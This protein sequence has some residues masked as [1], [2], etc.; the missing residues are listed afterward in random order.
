M[1]PP[2]ILFV[3]GFWEGPAPFALVTA[4]LQSAG[5]ATQ[6]ATLPSTGTS[7]PGNPSMKD[8]IAAV[9]SAIAGLVDTEG[10]TV[11]LVLHSAGGFVGSNA[12][13][14]LDVKARQ[15][16]GLKGGVCR[17]VFLTG[18]VFPE[19]YKHAS[20]PFFT[21]DVSPPPFQTFSSPASPLPPPPIYTS[22]PLHPL[23]NSPP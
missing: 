2:T 12:A 8:D 15:G 11:V 10:K 4:L 9:R 22:R 20:L 21:Y 1:A 7:S 23:T 3:P 19:G 6:T 13:E 16:A 14:G 17:I 18:A 5:Y